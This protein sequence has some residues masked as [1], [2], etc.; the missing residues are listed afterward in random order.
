MERCCL[1]LSEV[2][3]FLQTFKDAAERA[4]EQFK[5]SRFQTNVTIQFY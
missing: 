2:I 5:V 1:V 4:V 3:C